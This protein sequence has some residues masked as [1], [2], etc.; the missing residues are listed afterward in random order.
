MVCVNRFVVFI[1]PE[2]RD[3]EIVARV[4]EI[5]G[6]ASEKRG[7]LFRRKDQPDIGVFF[8]AIEMVGAAIIKRDNVAPQPGL[9]ERFLFDRIDDSAPRFFRS[10]GD[11]SPEARRC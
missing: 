6:I 4:F 7:R 9:I 8:V 11:W 5:I 1:D 10:L 3:V 2:K